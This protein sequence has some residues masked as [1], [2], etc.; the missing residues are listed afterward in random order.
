MA[1]SEQGVFR[2]METGDPDAP[3]HAG[4]PIREVRS[5][6]YRVA[7][8]NKKLMRRGAKT[9]GRPGDGNASPETGV[10]MKEILI[11]RTA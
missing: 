6:G 3:W 1:V 11:W 9:E 4:G 10:E 8:K 7:K 2:T 5:H